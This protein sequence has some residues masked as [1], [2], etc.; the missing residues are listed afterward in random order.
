[1]RKRWLRPRN[2]TAGADFETRLGPPILQALGV[3]RAVP[4]HILRAWWRG[5][6][7]ARWSEAV[8]WREAAIAWHPNAEGARQFWETQCSPQAVLHIVELL[9][10][11]GTLRRP[12]A[13]VLAEHVLKGVDAEG[14]WYA[15]AP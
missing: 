4:E 10:Q 15:Q 12:A 5:L 13:S 9:V 14:R 11:E 2:S 3:S 8:A 7:E 1:M 6:C